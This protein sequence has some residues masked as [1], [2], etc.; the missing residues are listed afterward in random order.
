MSTQETPP[1]AGTEQ[2]EAAERELLELAGRALSSF[3]LR[4]LTV[5]PS[6]ETPYRDDPRW[7][8]WT[9]WLEPEARRAHDIAR[10]IRKHLA[11]SGV[12]V[13]GPNGAIPGIWPE[14]A[15]EL[16]RVSELE[17]VVREILVQ[18][19]TGRPATAEQNA[20]WR[21]VLDGEAGE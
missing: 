1:A 10:R 9:R 6:L 3:T 2:A 15:P 20:R 12:R 19:A 8:P 17:Q 7:T 18:H 14:L 4:A 13:D 11:A 21:A 16:E 5:K